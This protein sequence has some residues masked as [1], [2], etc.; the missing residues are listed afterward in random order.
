MFLDGVDIPVMLLLCCY[1]VVVMV[2]ISTLVLLYASVVVENDRR[3]SGLS[4]APLD[5]E[6]KNNRDQRDIA[7]A[8]NIQHNPYIS[9]YLHI[10]VFTYSHIYLP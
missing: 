1:Y 8:L 6:Y 2:D 4:S 7:I 9:T 3:R 10:Y 5:I